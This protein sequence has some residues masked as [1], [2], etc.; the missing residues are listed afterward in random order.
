[1][2][3]PNARHEK[4]SGLCKTRWVERHTCLETFLELYEIVVYCLGAIV[5]IAEYPELAQTVEWSWDAETTTKAN[6]MFTLLQSFKTVVTFVILKNTLDY[7][8]SL[9][10]KL[11]QRDMDIYF[12]LK[13][14]DE[15][16]S[17]IHALRSNI[18]ETFDVLYKQTQTLADTIGSVEETPRTIAQRF[19][20]NVPAENPQEYYK[21][22]VLIPFI[23]ELLQQLNDRFSMDNRHV[24]QCLFSIIPS[25]IVDNA[26]IQGIA[27][28][29]T[30]FE[31]DLPSLKSIL[32]ELQQWKLYWQCKKDVVCDL[33]TSLLHCDGDAFPNI[34]QLLLLGCNIPPITSAEA[35]RSF[36]L[37]RRIKT[38]LRN[39]V[40][41]SRLSSLSLMA[42]HYDVHFAIVKRF[43]QKHPRRLHPPNLLQ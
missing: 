21:R 40:N 39:R 23:D 10:S 30:Q 2:Y 20:A 43:I 31:E 14:I 42:M 36:S 33:R 12:A 34:R 9:A 22:S 8:K 6:G 38:H 41:E 25:L 29:L 37:F 18:D 7:V 24:I 13:M 27:A 16:I 28:D 5:N 19:R 11:Q 15:V 17:N 4:L 1:M 32:S 3:I 35:E 26:N